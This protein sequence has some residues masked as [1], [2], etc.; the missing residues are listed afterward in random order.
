MTR[1][2]YFQKLAYDL[3]RQAAIK[4]M[5]KQAGL[6]TGLKAAWGLGKN[7]W[8]GA[9]EG[10]SGGLGHL[11]KSLATPVKS[12]SPKTYSWLRTAGRGMPKDMV[13]F[14]LFGGG[15]NA[16]L[17]DPGDRMSAF[18]K[19]FAGGA[20]SGVAW[21]GASNVLRRAQV[22]G[23]KALH[24]GKLYPAG[25]GKGLYGR[26]QGDVFKSTKSPAVQDA[27]KAHQA[28]GNSWF[29]SP[30]RWYNRFNEGAAKRIGA[31]AAVGTL[32]VAG[33]IAASSYTPTFEGQDSSMGAAPQDAGQQYAN[34]YT[35]Q[36]QWR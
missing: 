26:A 10:I 20:L 31:K 25:Q 32:P 7:L 21:R 14:G 13:S 22:G 33:A 4:E 28:A 27:T 16:A 8:S 17:A 36:Q 19:G 9:F 6:G 24:G 1:R 2:E 3:G 23:Y 29:T 11:G 12:V 30:E 5:E 18:G 34:P 15:I 35:Q